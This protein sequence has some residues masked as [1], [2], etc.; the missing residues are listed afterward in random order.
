MNRHPSDGARII[1]DSSDADLDLA[2]IIAYEHHIWYDG[3]GYPDIGRR[4]SCHPASD[5]LHV[6]DVYDALATNRP[7]RSAWTTARI[8]RLIE[9]NTGT[10]FAPAA[11]RAFLSMMGDETLRLPVFASVDGRHAELTG[12]LVN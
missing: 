10:E 4:R 1:L 2:A 3:R 11:S 7:Y 8:L 9:E 5:L 12:S 6:C